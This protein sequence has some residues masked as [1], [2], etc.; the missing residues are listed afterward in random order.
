MAQQKGKFN[1]KTRV[2]NPWFWLGLSSVA[3]TSLQ[4]ETESL[5]NWM[6]LWHA[7]SDT[8]QN[9]GKLITVMIAVMGV[10]TDYDA[11]TAT[12]GLP[13]ELAQVV[14]ELA[15][16]SDSAPLPPTDNLQTAMQGAV[17][18]AME[19]AAQDMVQTAM[20]SITQSVTQSDTQPE[21]EA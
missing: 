20:Q 21:T 13:E 9:P 15:P 19:V 6:A 17:Q 12:A 7:I 11:P 1:W 3:L 18:S 5:H 14:Q 16:D 8:L 2:K 4:I 10:I